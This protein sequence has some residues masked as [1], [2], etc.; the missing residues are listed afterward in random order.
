M[1]L[2]IHDVCSLRNKCRNRAATAVVSCFSKCPAHLYVQ[3]PNQ[4]L[5]EALFLPFDVVMQVAVPCVLCDDAKLPLYQ[6]TGAFPG[7]HTN[8][9]AQALKRVLVLEFIS[10]C[11]QPL[12]KLNS[13]WNMRE[14]SVWS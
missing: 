12:Q 14:P 4:V 3:L 10:M 5:R 1:I 13:L 7:E 6:Q 11:P 9:A 8:F 2:D